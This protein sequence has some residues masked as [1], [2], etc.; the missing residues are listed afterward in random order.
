LV[1]SFE[2]KKELNLSKLGV[3]KQ[4]QK[5]LFRGFHSGTIY[6]TP[7]AYAY[8]KPETLNFHMNGGMSWRDIEDLYAG[9]AEGRI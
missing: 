7:M 6:V 1:L 9:C 5:N 8:L 4:N 2:L 3:S